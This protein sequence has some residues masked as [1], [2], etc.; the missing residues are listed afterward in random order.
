MNLNQTIRETAMSFVLSKLAA[1]FVLLILALGSSAVL[2]QARL[3]RDGVVLYWGLVPAAVVSEKHALEDMHGVVPQDGGQVHH[4]VVALFTSSG[5]RIGDAVV[6]A[7]LSET[8]IVD[9]PPKY[10]TPMSV[11]GQMTYGQLFSTA[12]SGPYRFRVMVKLASRA[13]EIEFAVSAW[14]PHR[15]VR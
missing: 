13:T 7:Q 15:E 2:A 5:A 4:L 8:G 14:S 1:H 10:L 3:E 12:R 11:N 6:R 9:T